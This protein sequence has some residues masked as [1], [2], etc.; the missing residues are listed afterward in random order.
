[1]SIITRRQS[2]L[3]L[4]DQFYD[5]IVEKFTNAIKDNPRIVVVFE[6]PRFF[7]VER[8]T[9]KLT[10]A[11][12]KTPTVLC[13]ASSSKA[14]ERIIKACLDES[15]CGAIR[16]SGNVRDQHLGSVRITRS[17]GTKIMFD[18]NLSFD[19]D[20][21]QRHGEKQ[22]LIILLNCCLTGPCLGDDHPVFL[23]DDGAW[24]QHTALPIYCKLE[25]SETFESPIETPAKRPSE[26]EQLPYMPFQFKMRIYRK[27]ERHEF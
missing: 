14:K 25:S 2:S 21:V 16:G 15:A 19:N 12:T 4:L 1:M 18:S 22:D 20:F 8:L 3:A 6:T 11:W 13:I 27:K 5:T 17:D 9:A 7:L 26:G 24:M 10:T 23:V